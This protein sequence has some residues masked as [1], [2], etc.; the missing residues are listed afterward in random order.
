MIKQILCIFLAFVL[1]TVCP[2]PASGAAPELTIG[3]GNRDGR[4]DAMDALAALHA[5]LMKME[6]DDKLENPSSIGWALLATLDVDNSGRCD[7][8]DALLMLKRA[9]GKEAIFT[10]KQVHLPPESN[11]WDWEGYTGSWHFGI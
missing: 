9:V 2:L 11:E 10:R 6:Y 1:I 5:S 4:V 8:K 3:D 7:A